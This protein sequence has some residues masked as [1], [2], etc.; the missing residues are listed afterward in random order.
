MRE[1][2]NK[3][4]HVAMS[5]KNATKQINLRSNCGKIQAPGEVSEETPNNPN[6]NANER[7]KNSFV[8]DFLIQSFQCLGENERLLDQINRGKNLEKC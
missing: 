2:E 6:H 3:N 4:S 7:I 8:I 1:S 5:P